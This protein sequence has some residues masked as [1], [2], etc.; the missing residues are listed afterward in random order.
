MTVLAFAPFS[1]PLLALP[2]PLL[3]YLLWRGAHPGR[4]FREGWGFG[5]GLLGCGVF[6]MHISIDQ[7]GNVG[8]LTA[9]GI[10]LMFIMAVALYYGLVGWLAAR[11]SRR[12]TA[13][14]AYVLLFPS[15]WTL[16][17]WLRGWFLSGFPW[18][19]LGYSQIDTPLAGFAPLLGVYGLSW[20]VLL[21]AGL[22]IL[23]AG[24]WRRA[25]PALLILALAW[26]GGV[27]AGRIAWSHPAGDALRVSLLQGN[28][29]Q[30]LKWQPDMLL[31]TLKLFAGLSREN[32]DSDLVI[33]PETAV[34]AFAHQVEEALLQPLAEEAAA[35]GSELLIGI[36]VLEGEKN[37]YYNAMLSLG[38]ERGAYYKRHL[39]PFGEYMP[40]DAL[41]RP[42]LDWMEIPMSDF[43]S[44]EMPRPL[45]RVA[46]YPAAISICYEDVFGGE[47]IQ[48][49]P[50]AAF[51][52]NASNDAWFGDSLAPH[53]HL[54]MAR[55]RALET[56][57]YLLRSTNTGIS[58]L[59]DPRGVITQR[60]P[61]FAEH[62]LK[63]AI[64]P[65]QGM[66]PY[67]WGGDWLA[68]ALVLVL[69]LLWGVMV[70][71]G[72]A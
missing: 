21:S 38:E 53:Q 54:E 71:K 62:V 47:M 42:L 29:P 35:R 27:A 49:L 2:G 63:G 60:S 12:G 17:E 30:Q 33:W 31:P 48:A 13:T 3:M 28:I 67:S 4:A 1:L 8:T 44:G 55:M 46:G 52:I 36:P 39:V 14:A 24:G 26:G 50:E 9:I 23:L 43:S 5:L 18:L 40:L 51:L 41:L 69:L 25:L 56:G 64:R 65:M 59:I 22:L 10:T 37:R 68:V 20:L 6:W 70:R 72:A 7:F 15:L 11:L 34:P 58:A 57:R 16:V 19:S 32:W 66:T 61:A 45:L